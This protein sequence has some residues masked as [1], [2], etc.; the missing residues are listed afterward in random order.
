MSNFY[1]KVKNEVPKMQIRKSDSCCLYVGILDSSNL[2]ILHDYF[3]KCNHGNINH[4]CL[5]YIIEARMKYLLYL[6]LI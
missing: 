2:Y 3:T 1:R 6:E 4:S 5:T